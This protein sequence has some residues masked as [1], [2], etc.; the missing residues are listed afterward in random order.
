VQGL[1]IIF[2]P[3]EIIDTPVNNDL[4]QLGK[5]LFFPTQLGKRL[6]FP[7][8]IIATPVSKQQLTHQLANTS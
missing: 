4:M 5:R 1:I 2:F 3:T 7:A 6:F 8:E